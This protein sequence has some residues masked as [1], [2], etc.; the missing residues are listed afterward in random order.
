MHVISV[1]CLW[2]QLSNISGL[3]NIAQQRVYSSSGLET[4]H[5][6]WLRLYL[7]RLAMGISSASYS[8]SWPAGPRGW[9]PILNNR[10]FIF[11]EL[12]C[13][14]IWAR[15]LGGPVHL[16]Y[17]AAVITS[18]S[19][20]PTLSLPVGSKHEG[21]SYLLCWF[22]AKN[23]N[24]FHPPPSSPHP[25]THFFYLLMMLKSGIILYSQ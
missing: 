25:H 13:N 1:K 19:A 5:H 20:N 7:L 14:N 3:Q 16:F 4:V 23:R 2:S 24:F 12:L 22:K 17:K 11:N 18:T 15:D 9:K 8:Q 21:H 10:A 6:Q